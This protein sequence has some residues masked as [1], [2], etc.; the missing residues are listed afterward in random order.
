MDEQAIDVRALTK[1]YGDVEA[2]RGLTFSV[3]RGSLYGFLGRNGAGKTTTLKLLL[4]MARPGGGEGFVFGRRIDRDADSVAIRSQTAFVSE[5]KDL[6]PFATVEQM[7]LMTR[8]VSPGWR[9]DLEA[10]Y[11][12][13]FELR[14]AQRVRTLSRG[15]LTRLNLLLA[16]CR[17]VR[18]L[19]LDEPTQGL[20]VV[21]REEVLQGL[22]SHVAAEEA[23]ILMSSH[24]IHEVERICDRICIV[25]RGRAILEGELDELKATF[26]RVRATFAQP[27]AVAP[28]NGLVRNVVREG[29]T[30][31]MLVNG[32]VDSVVEHVRA[33][34][35]SAVDVD[36]VTLKEIF[37]ELVRPQ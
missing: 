10:R 19:I 30:V 33:L 8:S 21:I 28:L 15:N 13:L 37:L 11:L 12:K 17:G 24:E 34:D 4:G 1:N 23:T 20:D 35:A 3:P 27:T 14:P 25:D 26:R 2:L 18:L 9:T 16:L 29:R 31:S 36:T 5:S 22:V 6:Y 32:G 7:I